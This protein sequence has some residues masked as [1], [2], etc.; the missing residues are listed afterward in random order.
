MKWKRFWKGLALALLLVLVGT[1]AL[2]AAAYASLFAGR[3]ETPAG[4][5]YSLSDFPGLEAK[6]VAFSNDRGEALAG[7]LYR[8]GDAEPAG[9]V[10]LVH[11]MGYGHLAYLNVAAAFA[12]EGWLVFAYDATGNDASGGSGRGGVPQAVLDLDAALKT[13]EALPETQGLPVC[14]FG[15]SLGA[16]TVC[17]ALADHPEVRAAAA[18]SGFDGTAAY[19]RE[20]YGVPGLVLLP[21]ALLWERLRFGGAA[22]RTALEGFAASEARVLIV[23][24]TADEV[25]PIASGLERWEAVCG[26]DPRFTFLRVEGADHGGVF[27]AQVREACLELFQEACQ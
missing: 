16:Y 18:L 23:H 19:I 21:G 1:L 7:W 25:V 11:G 10:V 9:L 27:T 5:R 2:G 24:G 22:G 13:A 17:A 20:T 12:R 4:R 15:H 3:V 14:L 6:A 8:C 26:D